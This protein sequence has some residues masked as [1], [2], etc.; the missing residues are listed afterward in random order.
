MKNVDELYKKYYNA[1]KS[2]YD[3]NGELKE[4]KKKKFDYKQCEL[5]DEINKK[6]KLDE[7]TKQFEIIDNRDQGSKSTKK[8]DQEKKPDEIQKPLRVKINKNDFD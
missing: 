8:I 1:H 3:T 2:D 4:D 6:P 5:G 7:K